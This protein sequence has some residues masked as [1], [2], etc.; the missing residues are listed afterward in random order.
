VFEA[1]AGVMSGPTQSGIESVIARVAAIDGVV[2]VQSPFDDPR[3]LSKDGTIARSQVDW[4]TR[5]SAI[6][7][8]SLESS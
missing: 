7:S 4:A 6:K 3:F 8:K 1:P 2:A 5:A